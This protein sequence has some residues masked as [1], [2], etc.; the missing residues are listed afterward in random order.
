M[1]GLFCWWALWDRD[2]ALGIGRYGEDEGEGYAWQVKSFVRTVG[3]G[4]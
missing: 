2:K 3:F 4:G 1:G